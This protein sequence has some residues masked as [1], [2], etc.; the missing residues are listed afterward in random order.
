MA[1]NSTLP[2]T[3]DVIRDKDRSGVKTQIIGLDINIG[4]TE[5][6]MSAT[7]P[8][9]IYSP[10][11]TTGTSTGPSLSTSSFTVLA[12]NANRHMATFFNDSVNVL[13]LGLLATTSFSAYTVQIPPGGYYELPGSINGYTGIVTGLSAVATGSVV[14]TELS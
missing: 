7:N 8:L 6:L 2:A 14:V 5:A 10:A 9:P 4:G 3:A 12:A 11:A 13:F 1:D